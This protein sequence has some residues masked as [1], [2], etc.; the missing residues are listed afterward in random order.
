MVYLPLDK[1]VKV[2]VYGSIQQFKEIKESTMVNI[3]FYETNFKFFKLVASNY[4][5]KWMAKEIGT[6]SSMKYY[7]HMW[8]DMWNLS[9]KRYFSCLLSP[10]M[11]LNGSICKFGLNRRLLRIVV[12]LCCYTLS[13]SCLL[14][15]VRFC[16]YFDVVKLS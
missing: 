13:F 2:E 14:T 8:N 12:W 1:P 3:N 7:L 16:S 5:S 4:S 6:L 11:L 9:G 10:S 15:V